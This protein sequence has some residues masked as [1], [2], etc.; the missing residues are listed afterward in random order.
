M[1]IRYPRL[2][3]TKLP[4]ALSAI[5]LLAV[6]GLEAQVTGIV[7]DASN[8]QPLLAA[9]I[10]VEGTGIGEVT[11]LDGEY[12]LTTLDDGQQTLVFSYIGYENEEITFD[13]VKGEDYTFDV[14]LTPSG[15]TTELVTVTGQRQGQNAAINQQVKSNRIVNV[16]S[17]ER[18]R[19][20]PDE[21]AAESVGRLPGV[22]VSRS[23]G[24]G[25]R[26]NIRGLSPKFSSVNIDGVRIPATGQGRQVFNIRTGGGGGSASPQ[27][28]D[29]SVDLSMISSEALAGIEVYKSL[30]PDQD[31][32]AIG[33]SVNFVS[34]KAPK[35]QRYFFNVMGGHNPYHGSFNNYKANGVYS[36]RLL[37]DKFGLIATAAFSQIDRSVD[38]VDVGY[39]QNGDTIQLNNVSANDTD[40][41][42]RRYNASLAF[43]Y[44]LAGG[45]EI[46]LSG[47]YART[48][49]D[50][51]FRGTDL[52][53]RTNS[54]NVYAGV[55]ESNID[56]VNASLTGRHPVGQL[57]IDWKA[58]FIQTTDENPLSYSY[59]F[60]DN[61][62]FSGVVIPETDPYEAFDIY[63][64]DPSELNGGAAN[65]GNITRRVDGNFVG[66]LNL[67]HDVRLDAAAMSGF[68][69]AG[70][71]VRLKDR[72]RR[73][74]GSLLGPRTDEFLA[75]YEEEFPDRAFV[76]QGPPATPYVSGEDFTGFFEGEFPLRLTV[77]P[78]APEGLYN[79]FSD[80]YVPVVRPGGG[81]YDAVERIY[82]AYAMADVTFMDRVQVVGG[83][84]YEHFDADY[85]ANELFNYSEFLRADRSVGF[86]GEFTERESSQSYG[87]L[88]PMVNVKLG[89]WN[90]PDNSN[91]LDLRLAATR[92]LTRPDFYN[93]T[94]FVSID[95]GGRSVQRSEPNLL[96]TTAWNYD[97]FLTLFTNR[98]GLFSVGGF[99]KELE[100]I[101]FIYGRRLQS[102]LVEER[103]GENGTDGAFGLD[104]AYSVIEPINAPQTTYVRGIETEIQTNLGWLP[105]PFDGIVL[106]GN[107]TH[108]NSEAYYPIRI[109]GEFDFET[110]TVG[111]DID[112]VRRGTLPGQASNIANASIGYDKGPF[113]GRVSL[114]YQGQSINFITNNVLLDNYTDDYARIDISAKYQVSK[115]IS[116]TTNINNVANR[117]DISVIGEQSSIG[118][119]SIYGTMI[120]VG[121]RY[122]G[123]GRLFG[124]DLETP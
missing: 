109:P 98:Y 110:R 44:Q 43:D 82:A 35:E 73:T 37:D 97:A 101:D 87:E 19:E 14:A 58:T 25:Q 106:Y 62:P 68:L 5:V 15:F 63:R 91:G 39:V 18:I 42:R 23:G 75:A 34:A 21:N 89:L 40:T 71:K 65:R 86:N 33:G 81:D 95:V 111:P 38:A 76:R 123:S 116:I 83:L 107:F 120:W 60:G 41:D 36:R 46:F 8:G 69:K 7:T 100:N 112:T 4:L 117:R 72:T 11:D 108:I 66:Q 103:F 115:Q 56:L 84:R 94:P 70:G 47:N 54:A 114:N 59:G 29:R 105:S 20:L 92:A 16:V 124:G 27:V 122:S 104:N 2:Y 45:H 31:G 57:A 53:V 77:D 102:D 79:T 67:R 22:G 88:L 118:N 93:L 55:N 26:V 78:N 10:L 80:L 49:I 61:N 1:D 32:D 9:T 50:N 30:T 13:Y 3:I 121:L 52:R 12:R 74:T 51:T 90:D 24:E 48:S 85:V 17:A 6:G 96:P 99:Y 113:S 119:Q 64:A 28:D